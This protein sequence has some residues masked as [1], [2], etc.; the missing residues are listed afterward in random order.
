MS[1]WPINYP[2][3][4][5]VF[6]APTSHPLA[7]ALSQAEHLRAWLTITC[8]MWTELQTQADSTQLYQGQLRGVHAGV[9]LRFAVQVRR[10]RAGWKYLL[11]A[12][13]VRSPTGNPDLVHW[14][15]L[16]RLLDDRDFGPDIRSFQQQLQRA[17]PN[18]GR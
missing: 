10:E 7:P 9:A 5:V 15:P 2:T 4:T 14:L 11:L 6:T 3:G 17:L 12:F 16:E 18:L 8:S 13:H 1:F